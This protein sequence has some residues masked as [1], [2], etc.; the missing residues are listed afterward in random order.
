MLVILKFPKTIAGPVFETPDENKE[1]Q[2]VIGL[3]KDHGGNLVNQTRLPL[4]LKC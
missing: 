2:R 3:V 4:F 1:W